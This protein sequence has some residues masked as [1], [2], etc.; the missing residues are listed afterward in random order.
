MSV[1]ETFRNL[2]SV[3]EF[4]LIR[5]VPNKD[6]LAIGKIINSDFQV[7]VAFQDFFPHSDRQHLP[8]DVIKVIYFEVDSVLDGQNPKF[9]FLAK[10][11]NDLRVVRRLN[12]PDVSEGL[13]M[14]LDIVKDYGLNPDALSLYQ[15]LTEALKV[16]KYVSPE[17]VNAYGSNAATG[18][19][20]DSQDSQDSGDSGSVTRQFDSTKPHPRP[21]SLPKTESENLRSRMFRD[22]LTIHSNPLVRLSQ[23][24]DGQSASFTRHGIGSRNQMFYAHPD[25]T[26]IKDAFPISAIEQQVGLVAKL[27]AHFEET[28]QDL[29]VQGEAFGWGINDNRH[30]LPLNQRDFMAFAIWDITAQRYLTSAEMHP[31]IAKFQLKRVPTYLEA[32]PLLDLAQHLSSSPSDP[33]TVSDT[34]ATPADPETML[35]RIL[36]LLLKRSE[37]EVYQVAGTEM[38]VPGEGIVLCIDQPYDNHETQYFSFKIKSKA[39]EKHL[40]NLQKQKRSQSSKKQNQ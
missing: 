16:T 9:A 13:V 36:A 5:F 27:R 30:Q 6:K 22:L 40:E 23:K 18:V 26:Y 14:P 12:K 17:E 34:P 24:V 11:P 39:Y 10:K 37:A 8:T 1:T 3:R 25:G 29:S 4:Q 7:L 28:K 35:Q 21:S 31:L 15:N 20:Q 32:T 33:S 19:S 2:A 38:T